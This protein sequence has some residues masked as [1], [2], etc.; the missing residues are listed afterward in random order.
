M[1][2]AFVLDGLSCGGVER[3]AVTYCNALVE[4]GHSVTVINLL[5]AETEFKCELLP[6]V[7]YEEVLY[8]KK[9]G[10]REILFFN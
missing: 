7:K 6:E 5:P 4:R 8:S 10:T 3:V 9:N 1:K 2:F